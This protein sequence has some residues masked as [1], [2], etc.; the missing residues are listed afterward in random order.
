MSLATM[1]PAAGSAGS[2]WLRL[3]PALLVA[4]L[5]AWALRD[6]DLAACWRRAQAVPAGTWLLA[7][8]A[9]LLAHALR[10]MRLR[11]EWQR[12]GLVAGWWPALR[13]AL[14]HNA[15]TQLLPLRSG[16]LSY[17]WL[18][19]RLW[20]LDW[21]EAGSSLLWLR[22]QDAVVMGSLCLVAWLAWHR[23]GWLPW[24]AALMAG[25]LL[26]LLWALWRLIGRLAGEGLTA[27]TPAGGAMAAQAAAQPAEPSALRRWLAQAWALWCQR[28][29]G[30][31]GWW[32]CLLHWLAKLA[33]AAI[34]LRALLQLPLAA[35]ATAALGG[36]L[37]AVLPLQAPAGIGPYELGLAAALRQ[38]HAPAGGWPWSF[39]VPHAL[40]VHGLA[41]G[42]SLGAAALAWLSVA[43]Q[44]APVGTTPSF[45]RKRP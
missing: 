45:S 13:V 35:T 23:S 20:Q 32:L 14:W 5:L 31:L 40:L 39:I 10:G 8:A 17:V 6:A 19:K 38:V 12:Q 4:G 30:R 1:P 22:L 21:R 29:G 26:V 16:E 24:V 9:L 7:L 25:L 42:V 15:W 2:R 44:P 37:G 3:W 43:H 18:M 34:V 28:Q 27:A 41:I 11:L 36:E 33:A